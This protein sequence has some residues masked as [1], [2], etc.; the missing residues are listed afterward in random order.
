M[1]TTH[2]NG[3]DHNSQQPLRLVQ[4][5]ADGNMVEL[6]RIFLSILRSAL[7]QV[8]MERQQQQQEETTRGEKSG[9]RSTA[10]SCWLWT[11]CWMIGC[12]GGL[13]VF[14]VPTIQHERMFCLT[15]FKKDVFLL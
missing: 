10:L 3:V 8:L 15:M 6:G 5:F 4:I 13:V 9:I 14:G 11:I 7:L 2:R 1:Q 12:D